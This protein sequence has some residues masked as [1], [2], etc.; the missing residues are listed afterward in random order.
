MRQTQP[1]AASMPESLE[2]LLFQKIL[3][4]WADHG[5]DTDA[6]G[7]HERLDRNRAPV[8][9]DGKRAMVQARQIYVFAQSALLGRVP[10]A[11]THA[12][13]GRDFLLTHCR[14]PDG[15]WRF[16]VARNGAPMDDTR[17]LYTHAFILFAL[18]WLYRLDGDDMAETCAQETIAFL[19]RSMAHPLGGYHEAIGKDGK[20]LAGERRQNPHMHLLEAFLELYDA[21]KEEPWLERAQA[22]LALFESRFCVGNTLREYFDDTLAPLPGERG[23]IVE[24]GHHYEWAWLLHRYRKL[25]DDR[26]YDAMADQ[27]Y[28]FAERHG[29]DAETGG[30]VDIVTAK[31]APYQRSRRLWPQTEAIKAHI[32][33]CETTG[34]ESLEA[35]VTRQAQSLCATHL[36]GVPDGAWHEHISEDGSDL[37]ATFPASSLYHLT[38]AAAELVRFE[39]R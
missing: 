34:D 26:R 22:I 32:A 39:G 27:L 8:V 10:G 31:G 36:A 11:A 25:S 30:I 38:L 33:R 28:A 35:R 2:N 13:T 19:N 37:V 23:Q 18:A 15:G 9:S 16:R 14:H 7:F 3:P 24:P 4:F 29:V 20:P 6:G 1:G 21:T 17:D 5:I 12:L